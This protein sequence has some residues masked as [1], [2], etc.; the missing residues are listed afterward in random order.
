M[1]SMTDRVL[2][3]RYAESGSQEA[4]TE[5]VRRHTDWVYS[6]ALRLVHDRHLA[7]EVTQAVF[8]VLARK[9]QKLG[10]STSIPSWLFKVTRY[11]SSHVLRAEGRRKRHERKAAA[12][13]NEAVRA[14][15]EE[16]EQAERMLDELVA[17]LSS[18]DREAVLLRFYQRKSMAEV[19]AGLGVSEDAAK[20]RVGKAVE[21][22]RIL[23]SHKGVAL[24]AAA[25]GAALLANTTHAAPA[26]VL[27]STAAVASSSAT[28]AAAESLTIAKGA[29]MSM[30]T[31]KA[32]MAAAV[33]LAVLVPMVVMVFAPVFAQV[34]STQQTETEPKQAEPKQPA[35]IGDPAPDFSLQDLSGKTVKLSD[36]KDKTVVLEWTNPE[37]P[38]VQRYHKLKVMTGTAAKHKDVAW[39]A[40]ASGTS[41]AAENLKPFA[42]NNGISYPI[43]LD[44]DF[45]VAKA[46]GLQRTPHLFI[47]D[48]T[49]KLAYAGP[50]DSDPVADPEVPLRESTVNYVDKA[51]KELASGKSVN[52]P[53]RE[54]SGTIVVLPK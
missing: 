26:A 17:R 35:R 3:S 11:S 43:L 42:E 37:C 15:G 4:F 50:I 20:Q 40:I 53:R 41:A 54:V 29:M 14:A 49:G 8:I 2:L 18:Q 47:I 7:E 28:G 33:G 1:A 22:L 10:A 36:Y 32:K 13:T 51:L 46:Y 44:S 34:A 5:L 6:A 19:G 25:L 9:A 23:F 45:T 21:K 27:A 39:L 16:W 24:P 12:M 30:F 31:A 38:Y 48:K 52:M